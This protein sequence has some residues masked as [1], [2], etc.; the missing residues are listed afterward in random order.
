MADNIFFGHDADEDNN[1][2]LN[3]DDTEASDTDDIWSYD[4]DSDFENVGSYV[5]TYDTDL[6]GI[7]DVAIEEI[8][9]DGDGY[10][11]AVT[12]LADTDGDGIFDTAIEEADLNFDGTAD[13]SYAAQDTNND[14]MIDAEF[15]EADLDFDGDVDFA[16]AAE[17]TNFD[18]VV[19]NYE[20]GVASD[21]G[22][23][24]FMQATDLDFDGEFDSLNI[25]TEPEAEP[26]DEPEP[27]PETE[28]DENKYEETTYEED[29]DE[30]SDAD[31]NPIF[32]PP[33]NH[34][35]APSY[36]DDP[37]VP[38]E[39][40][41][42]EIPAEPDEPDNPDNPEY[43]DYSDE[44]DDA[45]PVINLDDFDYD[46]DNNNGLY[47]TELE[48]FDPADSDPEH[49]IGD[50]EEAMEL[51]E[52]QGDTNRCAIYSQKFVIEEFTGEEVDIEELVDVAEENGWF[53][54]GG[55]TPVVYMDKLLDYYGVPN[56]TSSG[57]DI[58]DIIE[59]LDEGHKIIVAVDADE[60]WNGENDNIYTPGDGVNHAIEVI[61][62][63]NSDPENPVVI[64]NDS[65]NPDG[66]GCEIPLE[67]FM[68]AWEDGD[69]YMIECL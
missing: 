51:W 25:T 23:T 19:D 20:M 1:L 47:Y 18:G 34:N 39:P 27:E 59:G 64:V 5:Q 8:D 11:D 37:E 31:S 15:M 48:N 33:D 49:V 24:Y 46:D 3:V 52:C 57:N 68:D 13:I 44:D 67:T 55:G 12:L 22:E 50:P 32:T 41:E 69:C 65:G 54:E 42:P 17:D 14:G 7:D 26:A 4:D 45:V 53:T 43:I 30:S 62:F 10:A 35:V 56:E 60:Y 36:P 29:S 58:N 66:C 2:G 21:D 28:P 6:D 61:G 38:A 40:D 9:L 16:I 63:D